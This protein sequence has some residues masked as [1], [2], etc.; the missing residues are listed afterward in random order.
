VTNYPHGAPIRLPVGSLVAVAPPGAG[1]SSILAAALVDA[2]LT[3]DRI[4]CRDDLRARFLGDCPDMQHRAVPASCMHHEPQVSE[5]VASLANAHLTAGRT[6]LYDQTGCRRDVLAAEVARAHAQGL[7]AVA[8]RRRDNSGASDVPL[9]FCLANNARR[10]RRVPNFVITNMH[11]AYATLTVDALY[12]IGFDVVVEWDERTTFEL[13]PEGPDARRITADLAIVGDI[14][15][16]AETFLDRLLPAVGTDRHLSNPDLLLV[17]VGDIHDK[18]QHS[19]EMIRWWLWALRTGRAVMTDSNHNK[20]LVR[21]LTRADATIRG[22]LAATLAE[23]EAQPD[24][25]LLKAEIVAAFSRLPNHLVFPNHVVAH[26]AMTEDRLFRTDSKTRSF[27]LYTRAPRTEWEW[28]G[29]QMLV[30]GHVIVDAPA[31]RRAPL[32]PARP[33]HVPGEVLCIDTGAYSGGGLTALLSATGELVRV[34]SADGDC[35][36]PERE[37][38][39]VSELVAAG[40]IDW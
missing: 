3:P 33:G 36:D 12:G 23:I 32:D 34:E 29:Q 5:A 7:A 4:V 26:A 22:S 40:I 14:H 19:V 17:S 30:H 37:A 1:K 24:A 15:G 13:L 27:A 10:N 39:Y 11:A 38:Q 31:R 21:A 20:S 9:E 16:C 8:L 25:A 35:I 2:G 6:W 18:G 28:T